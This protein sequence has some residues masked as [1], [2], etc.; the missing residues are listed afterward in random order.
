MI[1]AIIIFILILGFLIFIHEFGHFIAAK[2]LGVKVEEFGIGYPPAIWKKKK[3]ETIYSINL[4]PF[5]GFTKLYGEEGE[6][7]IKDPKSFVSQSPWKK[8]VI[9]IGGVA[10]NFLLAVIIFYF[11]L[12][13]SGFKS[14]LPLLPDYKFPLG[15]QQ[16]FS[17]ILGIAED[18]P[19]EEAGLEFEDVIL[20]GNGFELKDSNQLI[21]FINENKGQEIIL[22]IRKSATDEVKEVKVIPRLEI[23]EDQ[24]AIGIAIRDIAEIRYDRFWQK[25]TVGFLHSL[26]LSHYSLVGLGY[27]VKTSIIEKEVEILASSVVGPVGILALTRLTI[28][29]G[30]SQVIFLLALFSLALFILNI[31]PIPPLDGGRLAFIVF[32]AVTKKKIPSKIERRIQEAGI[33]FFIILFILVTFKDLIQFKD[34]LFKGIF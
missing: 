18:S 25:S 12:G 30:F 23:P 8:V 6:E 7:H 1:L 15:T 32:E 21:E 13:F 4:I 28:Q 20:K 11:L 5:G 29:E 2:R 14:Q 3:G 31:M 22:T 33:V 27:Y 16:N 26:N 34:I 19:A 10:M 9:T 24:G 17:M